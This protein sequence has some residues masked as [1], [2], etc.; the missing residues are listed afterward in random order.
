VYIPA[1]TLPT[2][3]AD[4]QN[5]RYGPG[6]WNTGTDFAAAAL[7]TPA[8][9]RM[10]AAAASKGELVAWDP[11]AKKARWTVPYP[12]A[13]NGG[14]L[15]TAGGLVFQG[16]LDGKFRAYNAADGGAALW[17]FDTTYPALSGPIAYEIDGEQYIAVTA[18]WGTALPLAGGVGVRDGQPRTALSVMGKVVVFKIGGAGAYEPYFDLPPEPTPKAADFGNVATIEHGKEVY[19]N[20]CMVCHGDSAQ[21]GGITT[22]LRWSGRTSS[23][24]SF[25]EIVIDGAYATAG[26]ASFKDKLSADDVE[27]VRAYIVNRANEDA[28]AAAAATPQ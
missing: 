24:E 17:E 3:Y 7:P 18:G 28:A 5:F 12:N 26:M 9:E 20:N 11:V 13:W 1:H 23:K 22:D 15:A 25:A 6:A 10:A 16:A 27:A 14:V 21:S 19:F 8:A 4:M 2:V